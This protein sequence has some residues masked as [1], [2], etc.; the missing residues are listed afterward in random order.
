MAIATTRPAAAGHRARLTEGLVA[1]IAEKS[2]AAV[3]IA[4]VARTARVSKR[5]F[6]EHFADKEACFLALYAEAS[7]ELLELV[8]TATTTAAGPWEA[9]IGAAARAYFERV[10]GEPELI[11]AALL[12]IHAAGPRARV[13]RREVQRRHA[14]QLLE[15]SRAAEAEEDGV[16]ALTPALV[17]AV[18]GGLD[19]LMLE[20]VEAGRADRLGELADAAAELIRAVLAR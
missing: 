2:Y 12:E 11:R 20:A 18:V 8:A 3:T 14:E 1:A 7:D 4:D 19:E 13:L 15:F 5:T 6:Y 17:T 9:R 10:A 16:R